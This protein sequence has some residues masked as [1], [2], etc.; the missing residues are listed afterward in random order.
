[1]QIGERVDTA[2]RREILEET[3]LLLDTCVQ[4]HTYSHP[5]RDPERH[6]IALVFICHVDTLDECRAARV[7]GGVKE[8]QIYETPAYPWEFLVR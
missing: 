4:Y 6:T 7:G 5:A 2:I 8:I 3:N 1:M